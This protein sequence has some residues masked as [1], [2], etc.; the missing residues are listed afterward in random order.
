[1]VSSNGGAS[2]A[3]PA[4]TL[5]PDRAATYRSSAVGVQRKLNS[6]EKLPVT[7]S[8]R[9]AEKQPHAARKTTTR[10]VMRTC[11]LADRVSRSQTTQPVKTIG[12]TLKIKP[13]TKSV[14][15]FP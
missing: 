4:T 5:S 11:R 15:V 12:R 10:P 2:V 1:A 8:N 14:N 3:E 9:N 13:N 7:P 6:G